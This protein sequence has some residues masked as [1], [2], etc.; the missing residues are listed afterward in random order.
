MRTEP[1]LVF[2]HLLIVYQFSSL[3]LRSLMD[4]CVTQSGCEGPDASPRQ[5]WWVGVTSH[6]AG[7]STDPSDPT[8]PLTFGPTPPKDDGL[9]W[10]TLGRLPQRVNDG[11]LGSRSAEAGVGVSTGFTWT[12]EGKPCC[13]GSELAALGLF[14][15]LF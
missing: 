3:L 11:T 12:E 5:Q 14:V 15:V 4:E 2:V 6:D 8:D 9:N 10:N 1:I 7:G 13:T